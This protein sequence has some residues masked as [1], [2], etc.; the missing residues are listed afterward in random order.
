MRMKTEVCYYQK[1]WT[2]TWGGGP[3]I[4]QNWLRTPKRGHVLGA[5]RLSV[6]SAEE[7]QPWEGDSQGDRETSGMKQ[8]F[9][10]P[11]MGEI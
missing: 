2:Q 4:A 7:E 3:K 11:S 9:V 8:T 5:W 6:L 10:Q 1:G